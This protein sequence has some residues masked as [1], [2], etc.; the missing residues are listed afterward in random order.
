MWPPASP[1]TWACY[2]ACCSGDAI[3]LAAVTLGD[4]IGLPLEN[5]VL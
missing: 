1:A 3:G 5:V 2:C 4:A